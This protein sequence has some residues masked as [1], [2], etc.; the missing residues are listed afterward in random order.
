MISMLL[1]E[2]VLEPRASDG[3]FKMGQYIKYTI[4]SNG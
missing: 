4:W 3:F 1:Y 2:R